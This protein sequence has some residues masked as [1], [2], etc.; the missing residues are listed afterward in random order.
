[1]NASHFPSGE[2]TGVDSWNRVFISAFTYKLLCF[3]PV[4]AFRICKGQVR[5]R[6]GR[7]RVCLPYFRDMQDSVELNRDQAN[8]PVDARLSA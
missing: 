2:N 5:Q 4:F 6:L 3:H 1:V 8:R 7:R